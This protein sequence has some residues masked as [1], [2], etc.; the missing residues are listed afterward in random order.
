M[1]EFVGLILGVFRE[2]N[3]AELQHLINTIRSGAPI[4]TIRTVVG[5]LPNQNPSFQHPRQEDSNIDRDPSNPNNYFD[6]W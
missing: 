5:Q 1:R 3:N 2:G 4:E 6:H